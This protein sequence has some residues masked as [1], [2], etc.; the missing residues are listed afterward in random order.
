MRAKNGFPEKNALVSEGA[1]ARIERVWFDGQWSIKK[2]RFAKTYRHAELDQSIRTKRFQAEIRQLNRARAA[3]V[4]VPAILATDATN[5]SIVL[6]RVKGKVLSRAL[7]QP[8]T[9]KF[10]AELAQAIAVLHGQGIVH[11]DL[12]TSNVLSSPKGLVIL[13]FGL[14]F[15]SHRIEDFAT[16]LLNLKKTLFAHEK[17][18]RW[19]WPAFLKSYARAFERGNAVVRAV[20]KGDARG[21]YKSKSLGRSGVL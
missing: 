11:G 20:E 5:T 13:D 17:S 12:T 3:G 19:F 1:E 10:P 4:R 18:A 14:S 2:T 9:K 16:D 7:D 15:F 21:R 6:E 8:K